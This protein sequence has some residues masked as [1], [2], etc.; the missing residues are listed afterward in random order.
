M[1]RRKGEPI[2]SEVHQPPANGA[3]GNGSGG[4]RSVLRVVVQ[5]VVSGGVGLTVGGLTHDATLGI[6]AGVAALDVLRDGM[7]GP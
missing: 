6:T 2:V 7:G 3:A 5:L 4:R 1:P